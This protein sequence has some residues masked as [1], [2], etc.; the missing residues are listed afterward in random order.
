MSQQE[1]FDISAPTA[2]LGS[3]EHE[4]PKINDPMQ[5]RRQVLGV[6]S[7][8]VYNAKL[9]FDAM[10]A[11]G[12]DQKRLLT[13]S[14]H[15]PSQVPGLNTYQTEA[16]VFNTRY[17]YHP[18]AIVM[19]TST[20]EVQTTY[21]MAVKYNLPV[22]VRTGGHDHAGESSGDNTV[23]IDIT[24]LKPKIEIDDDG[25][26]TIGAGY[27]F[28]E[29]TP[30]LAK[31]DRMIPHGTC[32]TVALSGFIQ[33]GGWGP[34]TRKHG[35][36]CEHLKEAT[37]I[38]GD[39]T[40]ITA[41][42]KQHSDILWALR[43]GGGMSYGIVTEW[44]VQTFELPHEIH[45]FTIEW[46]SPTQLS[47]DSSCPLP[48]EDYAT[49]KILT[50]WEDAINESNTELLGTNLKIN[51]KHF[52]GDFDKAYKNGIYHHCLMYGY[53]QG[54]ENQLQ[55]FI[56]RA[57]ASVGG[58]KATVVIY[59]ANGAG[60]ND[61]DAKYPV[62]LMGD[63]GR[64]SIADVSRYSGQGP[65]N[66]A[67]LQGTPFTPDYDAPAP[68]KISSKLVP[69]KSSGLW[70]DT[71]RKQLIRTLSSNLLSPES[72]HLGLFSYVTLGAI[73]GDFYQDMGVSQETAC[74]KPWQN[75]KELGVA[76]PYRPCQYT[77]QYQT[78]WNESI[79]NK[80]ELQTNKVFVDTN[81]AMDWIDVS[82]RTQIEG[83]YGAFISFKDPGI[84]TK[85]YFQDNYD[86][87]VSIK[88]T[89]VEDRFNHLR[90]RKT[91]I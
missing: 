74:Q 82:Q 56:D 4:D 21:H 14:N 57:F 58:T 34:W 15:F 45:R 59:P 75:P 65:G 89:Y 62:D 1:R 76:F 7:V 41:T 68:H 5:Q 79:K 44:K 84:A 46:N 12:F 86:E 78:W 29:L 54:N 17:Q 2:M 22:R 90:T 52:D 24:G 81:R 71:S 51:A 85:V 80:L 19:C 63:W 36:C 49:D 33:G 91:I 69:A 31:Q 40:R 48:S 28:Y 53:W 11:Q 73:V 60:Q 72:E 26:A 37:I 20:E 8:M 61:D 23:L 13:P 83:A 66:T 50:A 39:G 88:K 16:M 67:L 6:F 32:A 70:N 18:F 9:F 43:G 3:V 77:I 38:L 47:T 42:E 27:R 64:N 25:I 35:M 10:L 55:N 87:L 30:L